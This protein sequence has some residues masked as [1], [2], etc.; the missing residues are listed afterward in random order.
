M[1]SILA[2]RHGTRDK[3]VNLTLFF[4]PLILYVIVTHAY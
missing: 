3:V 2:A 1:D 4:L